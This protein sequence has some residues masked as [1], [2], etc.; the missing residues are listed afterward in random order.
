MNPTLINQS[1][2]LGA[3][4]P[5]NLHKNLLGVSAKDRCWLWR[6][7]FTS[8]PVRSRTR[9]RVSQAA[10]MLDIGEKTVR[11]LSD[12]VAKEF[13]EGVVAIPADTICIERACQV[14]M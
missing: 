13:S 1:R 7:T 3:R 11:P 14:V 6:T 9:R 10:R 4:I 5:K 8:D 2:K 12:I